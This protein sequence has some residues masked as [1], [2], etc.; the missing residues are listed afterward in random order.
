M[1]NLKSLIKLRKHTV[2]E[3]QR[4][5]ANL[6]SLVED[7]ENKKNVLIK[8]LQDERA[9]LTM[10]SP[11]EML[12]YFGRFSENVQ[13]VLERLN[14]EKRKVEER[15]VVAQDDVRNAFADMKRIEIVQREREKAE[16]KKQ[17]AKESAEMDEIGLD[18][19]RRQ[20]E[21]NL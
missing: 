15:I 21:D 5:L 18:G 16:K 19:F 4:N 1:A 6:Y 13:R 17:E 8:R 3:K 10:D 20:D 9:A 2:D 12:G 11:L 14:L 7:I